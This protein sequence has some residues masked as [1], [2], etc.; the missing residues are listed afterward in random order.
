M[1][2]DKYFNIS[3]KVTIELPG[4]YLSTRTKHSNDKTKR[5]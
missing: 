2:L 3:N 1:S 5:S 4:V